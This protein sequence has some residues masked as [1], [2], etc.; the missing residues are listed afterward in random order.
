MSKT[1]DERS[2]GE[3]ARARQWFDRA[4]RHVRAAEA[5]A[6]DP[7]TEPSVATVH[8]QAAWRALDALWGEHA[9]DGS[10]T[11]SEGEVEIPWLT[12][13]AEA[14]R[15]R[16]V[17]WRADSEEEASAEF[18]DLPT[19]R[20][21]LDDLSSALSTAERRLF[22]QRVTRRAHRQLLLRATAA[23]ALVVP[24][25][26]LI[27]QTAPAMGEGPWIAH[28]YANPSFEGDPVVRHEGSI[29][30]DWDVG[31]TW[32]GGPVDGFSV[33]W[34]TCLGL[35]SPMEVAFLLASDDG[36][37]LFVNDELVVDNWGRH[38]HR[39]RGGRVRLPAGAHALRVE[40]FE[41]VGEA[42][43]TLHASLDGR[44]PKALPVRALRRP[45]ANG[46]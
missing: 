35:E 19:L 25:G 22:E 40:Y 39:S 33:R 12:E 34:R 24:A 16:V 46:C 17:A 27:W 30:H 13:A 21:C 11:R 42:S 38:R 37:R 5:I 29:A 8:V 6:W 10:A 31:A 14:T 4:T 32:D 18:E 28:Y 26:V 9:R 44:R 36:A 41:Q 15:A 20:V 1:R 3:D 23:V 2:P 43:V 7:V 45:N